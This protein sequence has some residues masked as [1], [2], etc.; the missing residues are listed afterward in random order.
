MAKI[1]L[2][3]DIAERKKVT[4]W[5]ESQFGQRF[6]CKASYPIGRYGIEV[7]C[8]RFRRWDIMRHGGE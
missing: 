7:L 4:L 8:S 1:S 6:L 3:Y 5:G 2:L